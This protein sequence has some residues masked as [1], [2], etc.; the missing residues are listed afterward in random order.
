ML[1]GAPT[2]SVTDQSGVPGPWLDRLP[3]FRMRVHPE[4]RGRAAERV[5]RRPRRRRWTRSPR[6]AGSSRCCARC[7]RTPRSAPSR[8]TRCGSAAP[9][10]ADVVGLPLHLAARRASRVCRAARHRGRAPAARRPSALGQVLRR[11]RRRARAALPAVGRTSGRCASGRTRAASSATRSST[12]CSAERRADGCE[13]LADVSEPAPAAAGSPRRGAPRL[14]PGDGAAPG[15][16]ALQR[17]GLRRHQHGRPGPRARLQQ[18]RDLPPRAEQ[19]PPA[20][21]GPRRGPRRADPGHRGGERRRRRPHGIP[22][23]AAGGAPQR[24]GA[25][26]AP[27]GRHPAAAGAGQQRGRAGRA[28]PA[29]RDRRPAGRARQGGHRRG[30]AA[31]RR[32]RRRW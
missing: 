32:A 22:A 20:V 14:R 10:S 1:D 3:H 29:P 5:P 7:S 24:R 4:P 2:E 23:A 19:D 21:P 27:A 17:A 25:G 6:C 15:D 18:V 9:T 28:A 31:H 13:S 12:A 30:V 26:R 16:R 11:D 8:A